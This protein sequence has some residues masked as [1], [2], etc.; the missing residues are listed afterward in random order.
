MCMHSNLTKFTPFMEP[1]ANMESYATYR[2]GIS[3]IKWDI[4]S[5]N[6][7]HGCILCT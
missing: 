4:F 1:L 3:Y 5:Y 6:N 7:M 2:L